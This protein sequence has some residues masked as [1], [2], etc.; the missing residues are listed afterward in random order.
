MGHKRCV[1]EMKDGSIQISD[2]TYDSPLSERL[3]SAYMEREI[4]DPTS[5]V[6]AFH[7]VLMEDDKTVSEGV[8]HENR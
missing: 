5:Y 3:E 4:E 6:R 2:E 1:Y 7:F 8:R